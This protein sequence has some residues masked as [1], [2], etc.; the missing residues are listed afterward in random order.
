MVLLAISMVGPLLVAS[1]DA[2]TSMPCC[3]SES[4]AESAPDSQPC[5]GSL[6]LV[7]CDDLAVTPQSDNPRVDLPNTASILVEPPVVH[8]VQLVDSPRVHTN[9][10]WLSTARRR[11]VVLRV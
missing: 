3:P 7:C 8:I 1:A 4:P 5:N 2:A 9:L 6:L 11:S 10:T